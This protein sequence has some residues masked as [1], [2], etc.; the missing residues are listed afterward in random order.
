M[1]FTEIQTFTDTEDRIHVGG[2]WLI[3]DSLSLCKSVR[4]LLL[5]QTH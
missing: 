2:W 5:K 3:T 1:H 4:S